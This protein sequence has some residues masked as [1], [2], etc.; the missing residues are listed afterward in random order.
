MQMSS[1]TGHNPNRDFEVPQPPND[2]I[3]ALAFSPKA[4]YFVASSWDNSVSNST[5]KECTALNYNFNNRFAVGRFNHHPLS[6]KLCILT[7][8]LY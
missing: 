4:N 2:G 3:S 1:G 8:G 7:K 5:E 6:Q